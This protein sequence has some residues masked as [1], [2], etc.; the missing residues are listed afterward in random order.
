MS[1]RTLEQPE[2]TRNVR[3]RRDFN[4]LERLPPRSKDVI[5]PM[6]CDESAL[7]R[8]LMQCE[9]LITQYTVQLRELEYRHDRKHSAIY[10]IFDNLE[11]PNFMS[12]L[13]RSDP[14]ALRR[15]G[16][17]FNLD[18]VSEDRVN[19]EWT[20]NYD[21]YRFKRLFENAY[22]SRI[23]DED[24]KERNVVKDMICA[25]KNT[26]A[27]ITMSRIDCRNDLK[28]FRAVLGQ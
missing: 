28:H 9:D 16:L 7:E 8:R 14:E 1:K 23:S 10:R 17:I 21:L 11:S 2:S 26:Q 25:V 5:E 15:V 6:L 13:I 20:W 18:D 27:E 12:L 3:P 4:F 19:V 24:I 22:L